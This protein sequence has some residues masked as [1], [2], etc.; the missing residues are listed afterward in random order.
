MTIVNEDI[1]LYGANK[2][3]WECRNH[4]YIVD[5]PADTGKT[6][7]CL[8]KLNLACLKYPGSRML[9][10]RQRQVDIRDSVIPTLQG[11]IFIDPEYPVKA[12]G[13]E[14]VFRFRYANGSVIICAGL[15]KPG[16]A[17]SAEYDW[18]YVNQA[19]QIRL[20]GW[21]TLL[22]RANGRHGKTAYPLVF[23]DS[24]PD[25]PQHWIIDR[26]KMGHL[27]MFKARHVDNP[28]I[29]DQDTGVLTESGK[30][31]MDV[32]N[33]LTGIRRKRLL[34][35]IWCGVEGVVYPEWD[36]K[37]NVITRDQLPE[38]VEWFCS[39]DFGYTNPFTFGLY[40][41][42]NDG[43]LYLTNEIYMTRRTVKRHCVDIRKIIGDK[44]ITA[45]VC[46]HDAEGRATLLEEMGVNAFRAR[47]AVTDGIEKVRESIIRAGDGKPR[48]YVVEDALHEVDESLRSEHRPICTMDEYLS[49]SY[50]EGRD[51]KPMKEDPIKDNDHAMDRDRYMIMHVATR[52]RRAVAEVFG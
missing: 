34:E 27:K 52:G 19:E 32:L 48:Y 42:D 36:E 51:G 50:H 25:I 43:R 33:K 13:G 7:G 35:G 15:D 26:R 10:V 4:E 1:R 14:N 30:T 12:I 9:V 31:R 3:A 17:L 41:R 40:L 49:Y 23:G 20:N 24:N 18:I 29:Y 45:W 28:T 8:K 22:T 37:A 21:E 2:D 5:G 11:K 39:I 38:A 47:K 16:K 46:D 44:K 6:W